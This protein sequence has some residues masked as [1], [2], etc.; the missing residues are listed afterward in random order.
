MED[1]KE[2]KYLSSNSLMEAVRALG[3]KQ[4]YKVFE[5]FFNMMVEEGLGDYSERCHMFHDSF[6]VINPRVL[7]RY[8]KQMHFL[9]N[10]FDNAIYEIDLYDPGTFFHVVRVIEPLIE[11]K[12]A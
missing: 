11:K 3:Y 10:D 12:E 2:P 8:L 7:E 9:V 6:L 5:A 1:Y 4:Q